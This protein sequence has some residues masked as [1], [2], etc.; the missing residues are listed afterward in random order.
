MH[1]KEK[2]Y[3]EIRSYLSNSEKPFFLFHDDPDGLT[4]YLLLKKFKGFGKGMMV[5]AEP[6][7]NDRFIAA[8][9]AAKPDTI[10]IVDVALMQQSFVD[11]VKSELY[12]VKDLVWI[13]HHKPV[14]LDGVHFYNPRLHVPE[15]NP[16]A[17]FL[18]YKTVEQARSQDLWLAMAGA[19]SDWYMPDYA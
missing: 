10:F 3:E 1:L 4:S 15:N 16:P 9:K 6:N 14:K 18:C 12:G 8:V 17:S 7:V 19:V 2:E 11:T 5:K 13:D